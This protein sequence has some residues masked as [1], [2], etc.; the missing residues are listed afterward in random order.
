MVDPAG[1][2][3]NTK[4][5]VMQ[6][7]ALRK[8]LPGLDAPVRRSSEWPM[9]G[10]VRKLCEEEVQQLIE[11]YET[12]TTVYELGDRFG[13]KRQTVSALLKRHG[14]AMRQYGLNR[15]Q[16]DEAVRL[17]G[18]GWSLARIGG[19]FDTTANTVRARLLERGVRMR[20]VHGRERTEP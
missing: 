10:R 2:Y 9:P 8:Q 4:L 14:V 7:E 1:A 20:D 11:G 6:L 5:Q 15:E 18:A 16:V 12:G 17:Y 13:I 3:S 19:R